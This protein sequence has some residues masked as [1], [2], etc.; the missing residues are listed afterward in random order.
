[1]PD[2]QTE[3]KPLRI[4]CQLPVNHKKCRASLEKIYASNR[5]P[6]VAAAAV[7]C[8]PDCNNPVELGNFLFQE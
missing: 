1:M 3:Y 7:T 5:E 6:V 8:L 2:I 4:S